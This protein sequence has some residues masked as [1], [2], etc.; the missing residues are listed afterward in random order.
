MKKEGSGKFE[1]RIIRTIACPQNKYIP[2][3]PNAGEVIDD[4]Q[5]M[6][7]GLKVLT[8]GYAGEFK[9]NGRTFYEDMLIRNRGVHEPQEERMFMEVLKD[10]PA[11]GTM[12]EVGAWWSFYSMWFHQQVK[13]ANN[14]MMEPAGG[15]LEIGKKNFEMNGFTGTF[16]TARIPDKGKDGWTVDKWMKDA[17]VSF[18]DVLHADIQHYELNMLNGA[19]ESLR[20]NK[21]KYVFVGGHSQEL[22][23][24]CMNFLKDCGFEIIASADFDWESNSLDSILVARNKSMPGVNFTDVNEPM[25]PIPDWENGL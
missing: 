4:Y 3:V 16:F 11:G 23:F 1:K 2:R 24:D 9:N 14:Y 8:T 21:I 12:L 17:E 13:N 15:H 22:H 18:L 19:E 20:N 10:I 7:N 5:I 6:H 25:D